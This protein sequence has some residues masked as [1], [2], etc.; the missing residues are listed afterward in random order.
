[1]EIKRGKVGYKSYCAVQSLNRKLTPSFGRLSFCIHIQ[2]QLTAQPHMEMS[3]NA[4]LFVEEPIQEDQ[5]KN[6]IR[7]HSKTT[8]IQFTEMLS[9]HKLYTKILTSYIHTVGNT[10][11]ILR[12]EYLIANRVE[13]SGPQGRTGQEHR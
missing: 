1:M 3:Q 11:D 9:H 7:K 10:R 6:N 2:L 8:L 5:D 12:I 13:N 4:T